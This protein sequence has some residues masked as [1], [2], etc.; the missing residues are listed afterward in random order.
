[1]ARIEKNIVIENAHLIFKNFS[2]EERDYNPKGKRNFAV[3]LDSEQAEILKEQGWNIKELASKDEY[4]EPLYFLKVSVDFGKY[5]PLVQLVTSKNKK[6]IGEDKLDILD[7][8]RFQTV[9]LVIRPYNWEV[10]NRSGVKAYL[11]T[12]VG[13]LEEDPIEEKYASVP[14]AENNQ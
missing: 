8:A 13:V 2:G 7:Y 1:M 14:E 4:E 3:V 11:K 12:F 5:P 6:S 9:D 10:N